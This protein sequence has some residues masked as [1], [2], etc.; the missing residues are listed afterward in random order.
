MCHLLIFAF[1]KQLKNEGFEPEFYGAWSNHST[2]VPQPLSTFGRRQLSLIKNLSRGDWNISL[3]TRSKHEKKKEAE[4]GSIV[5][6]KWKLK[7]QII[8]MK[9]ELVSRDNRQFSYFNR[10]FII[11]ICYTLAQKLI[12]KRIITFAS[13]SVTRWPDCVFNTWPFSAISAMKMCQSELKTLP[14]TK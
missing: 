10:F 6:E 7:G 9:N 2:N 3:A 5:V 4:N 11:A 13:T 8:A 1:S 14:K 12:R